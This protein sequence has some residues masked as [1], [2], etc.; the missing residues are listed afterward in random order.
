M[1][2]RQPRNNNGKAGA[3]EAKFCGNSASGCDSLLEDLRCNEESIS[4][5]AR[6]YGRCNEC[7][8]SD[9]Q[10]ASTTEQ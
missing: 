9:L 3:S 2:D 10:N 4:Y 8:I 5:V 6:E 1:H 7:R